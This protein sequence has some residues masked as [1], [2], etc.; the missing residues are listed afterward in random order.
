[1]SIKLIRKNLLLMTGL[2]IGV[3]LLYFLFFFIRHEYS[4]YA[5]W[6]DLFRY[7]GE[8]TYRLFFFFPILGMVYYFIFERTS[9]VNWVIRY[10]DSR[11]LLKEQGKLAFVATVIMIAVEC[12]CMS[13]LCCFSGLPVMNWDEG[14]SMFCATFRFTLDC[15][16]AE[17][18]F[19]FLV[20]RFMNA[21]LLWMSQRIC[22]KYGGVLWLWYLLVLILGEMEYNFPVFLIFRTTNLNIALL[23][24][25]RQW[26]WRLLTFTGMGV[27][28]VW[29]EKRTVRK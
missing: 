11:R 24:Q 6:M 28:Y 21:A 19:D 25:P 20:L 5:C 8:F 12:A 10:A 27:L 7:E 3:E 23:Q 26:W 1:M 9:G 15:S 29:L 13:L 17:V 2:V 14:R 4:V 16:V 22:R 18:V